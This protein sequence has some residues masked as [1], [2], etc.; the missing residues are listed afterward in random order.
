MQVVY[1][2]SPLLQQVIHKDFPACGYLLYPSA[3][4]PKI[5]PAFHLACKGVKFY[6]LLASLQHL[7]T[8]SASSPWSC[9]VVSHPS[10]K[11]YPDQRTGQQKFNYL[12]TL[13]ILYIIVFINPSIKK[14][15]KYRKLGKFSRR[16]IGQVIKCKNKG[17]IKNYQK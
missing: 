5:T 11:Y 8:K 2:S 4:Q 10:S 3:A 17:Q 6:S 15:N 14:Q 16:T 9:L 13:R 1:T 12:M 7:H